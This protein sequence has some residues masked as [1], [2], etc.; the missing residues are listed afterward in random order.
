MLGQQNT[1]TERVPFVS[2]AICRYRA[3]LVCRIETGGHR[4]MR[5]TR[6]S[7]AL[8][9]HEMQTGT[10]MQW[11]YMKCSGNDS[12]SAFACVQEQ[13]GVAPPQSMG[14]SGGTAVICR[15]DG[16]RM[17]TNRR[18]TD[19]PVAAYNRELG[20]LSRGWHISGG[21]TAGTG[22][23]MATKTDPDDDSD[24]IGPHQYAD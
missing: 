2:S 23:W 4:H 3:R 5:Q 20:H 6:T 11:Y 17:A 7:S 12:V 8:V 19:C 9:L 14:C 15:G 1:E 10:S 16:G 21:T 13:Q 22:A 24:M 18:D